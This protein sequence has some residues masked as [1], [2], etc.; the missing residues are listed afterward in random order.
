VWPAR[1]GMD[2]EMRSLRQ[3]SS[4]GQGGGEEEAH[5]KQKLWNRATAKWK[6]T[7][8]ARLRNRRREQTK[9]SQGSS[10]S[11]PETQNRHS[12]DQ[13]SL[14]SPPPSAATPHAPS[15]PTGT[16]PTLQPPSSISNLP[17]AYST[18]S[19]QSGLSHFDSQHKT[20]PQRRTVSPSVS[21]EDFNG[22]DQEIPYVP[23]SGHVATDDKA[24]LERMANCASA[25]P[26]APLSDES[27]V[28]STSVPVWRDEELHDF[29]H[30]S[31]H[32]PGPS[33][34]PPSSHATSLIPP[35]PTSAELTVSDYYGF[36]E[37][38]DVF[39]VDGPSAPPFEATPN[40]PSFEEGLPSAPHFGGGFPSAPAFEDVF[41]EPCAPPIEG[42]LEN[43][44]TTSDP[45]SMD[46]G[47][48]DYSHD[49]EGGSTDSREISDLMRRS[50]AQ[51]LEPPDY[52][53]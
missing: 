26:P 18:H 3:R 23:L 46:G 32:S 45:P 50:S 11:L 47:G 34:L 9:V 12:S 52:H 49:Q 39:I 1:R 27:A 14:P 33:T 4:G 22:H 19:H 44:G 30:A 40:A 16:N 8:R 17:P 7:A 31:L 13:L 43:E 6:A 29:D 37:D 28:A 38:L 48:L 42:E 15:T 2:L 51:D 24:T 25:P 53:P 5:L 10:V 41:V 20:D 21:L 35:P 36:H